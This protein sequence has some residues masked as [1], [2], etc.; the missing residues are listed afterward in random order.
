MH[1]H[2]LTFIFLFS[3][4]RFPIVSQDIDYTFKS[5]TSENGLSNSIIQSIT[6]DKF[7]FIWASTFD[8]LNKFDGYE[9]K[10][11]RTIKND[12]SSLRSN[13]V[14]KVFCDSRKRLWVAT[15]KGLNLYNYETDA[16]S[17]FNPEVAN[18]DFNGVTN[19]F[20]DHKK[21]IWVGTAEGLQ[22]LDEKLNKLVSFK[23]DGKSKKW[24]IGPVSG[25]IEDS[26]NNIYI[27]I[28]NSLI[29]FNTSRK[30][31]STIL[32]GN[33]INNIKNIYVDK[34]NN[35]WIGTDN[36]LCKYNLLTKTPEWFR[37]KIGDPTTLCSNNVVAVIADSANQI[38]VGTTQG[39]SKFIE[40]KKTFFS[41]TNSIQTLSSSA[42]FSLFVDNLQHLWVGTYNGLNHV[43]I[44]YKKFYPYT[45]NV[46]KTDGLSAN[47]VLN[48]AY[49]RKDNDVYVATANGL[50]KFNVDAKTFKVF[51]NDPKDVFS[52]TNNVCMKLIIDNEFIW[53]N[54]EKGLNVYQK[55]KNRFINYH[56]YSKIR[57]E[58]KFID[59]FFQ[60]IDTEKFWE[61]AFLYGTGDGNIVYC[62]NDS[63]VFF[64]KP[65]GSIK[66][67]YS[68]TNDPKFIELGLHQVHLIDSKGNAWVKTNKGIDVLHL[69]S[70]KIIHNRFNSKN[71]NGLSHIS[72]NCV[73]EDCQG[74]IWLGTPEGISLQL[75]DGRFEHY[76][77]K[78]GLS[79]EFIKGM[80]DQ[81]AQYMWVSTNKGIS[82]F[83]KINKTFINYTTK[84]G[85]SC[86]EF[87][88][89]VCKTKSGIM[90]FGG[91]KGFTMF[92]PDSILNNPFVGNT[93]IE[94]F[95][96]FNKE[97]PIGPDSPLKKNISE[98]KEVTLTYG[99][100]FFSM[101]FV[102]LNFINPEQTD[103]AYKLDGFDKDWNFIGNNRTA[104]YTNLDP[105]K[106]IFR[107]M[108]ANSDGIWG[109]E[110]KLAITVEPPYYKT[111]WFI[112]V[113]FF[114][115]MGMIA[116]WHKWRTAEM[117]R[118]NKLLEETVRLR[119]HE[120]EKAKDEAENAKV[121]A[122]KASLAKSEFLANM[123]HEI[124]TPM[125][126]VI[127]MT[128]L[129][130]NTAL[131]PE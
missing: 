32:Q 85:L 53:I 80:L 67:F 114:V 17:Y 103:Y 74:R 100:S 18:N 55:S 81:N 31:S 14:S 121:E 28:N 45:H 51:K 129:L 109:K 106:Y 10:E 124:R 70:G 123:S 88:D 54:T 93:I 1:K 95:H 13:F 48:F 102:G 91:T 7:G 63:L 68:K 117:D 59:L 22:Y 5:Y 115:F 130:M 52:L 131:T 89:A 72:V 9:F 96:L 90:F 27:A 16:F 118:N 73:I 44:P 29:Y 79:N 83:D 24:N 6:Q 84:D 75:K 19:I 3:F 69:K 11:Y 65:K 35:L 40:S 37:H 61:K 108:S 30:E 111:W 43:Y 112:T 2:I 128:E 50:N 23:P 42:I 57:N 119:T 125:N 98:T 64:D 39:L 41:Y 4:L 21:T 120:A 116:S 66:V 36:G 8:G 113:M 101:D 87:Y 76:G 97:V 33:S 25:F 107:V 92:H 47:A 77:S 126:G 58:N 62:N 49:D 94:K 20:E 71:K 110:T 86:N 15:T 127:G 12:S 99:Q 60:K 105:G 82:K 104:S 78:E 34:K 38:W 46:E 56:N 122:E 26:F